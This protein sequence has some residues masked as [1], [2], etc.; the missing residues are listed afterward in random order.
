MPFSRVLTLTNERPAFEW[1]YWS[2][3][4]PQWPQVYIVPWQRAFGST[5]FNFLVT[6]SLGPRV[7]FLRTL[8]ETGRWGSAPAGMMIGVTRGVLAVGTY[9][10][11]I[12]QDAT[13]LVMGR[14]TL[15]DTTYQGGS[16]AI[17][18]HRL[19]DASIILPRA[20][21]DTLDL[22]GLPFR[23]Y[24][25]PPVGADAPF[26]VWCEVQS[27]DAGLSLFAVGSDA[28][29]RQVT[30]HARYDPR[31]TGGMSARLDGLT[32]TVFSVS[33]IDPYRTVELQLRGA[34]S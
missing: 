26:D 13:V 21:E 32:Y 5:R 28:A 20:T 30:V 2:A 3:P 22:A 7:S 12:V 9:N 24:H 27:R 14:F 19:A 17:T 10:Y 25:H 6:Q 16:P 4:N 33:S 34:A 1:A 18:Y 23:L 15:T 29:S 31:I 8:I 11:Q